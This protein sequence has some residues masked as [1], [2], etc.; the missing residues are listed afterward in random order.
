MSSPG[1]DGGVLGG[2][3]LSISPSIH[4]LNDFNPLPDEL[5]VNSV[6]GGGPLAVGNNLMANNKNAF[7]LQSLHTPQNNNDLNRLTIELMNRNAQ[8]LKL[9]A[10]VDDL[11][12]KVSNHSLDLFIRLS[13]QLIYFP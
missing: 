9:S 12:R 7:S 13:F 11:T 5:N 8:I 2:G 4:R 10:R 1:Y 6:G 3:G